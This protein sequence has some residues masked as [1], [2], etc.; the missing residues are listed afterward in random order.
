MPNNPISTLSTDGWVRSTKNILDV[1]FADF[2]VAA[3]SQYPMAKTDTSIS[4]LMVRH[5]GKP[6]D[7]AN[8]I[9]TTL[10]N[11]F[12]TQFESVDV[13][14]SVEPNA[15]RGDLMDLHIAAQVKDAD[16]FVY[17]LN[18]VRTVGESRTLAFAEV[19]NGTLPS[20]GL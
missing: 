8:A 3:H 5:Q 20:T 4:W 9:A 14:C 10:K 2:L 16:G 18:E 6:L 15:E 17:N 19:N 1:M 12:E 11:Y 13:S 7:L